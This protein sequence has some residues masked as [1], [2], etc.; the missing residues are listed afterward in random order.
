MPHIDISKL[1]PGSPEIAL[2]ARWRVDAFAVLGGDIETERATLDACAADTARHATLIA[3]CDG[4]PAGTCLLVPS[5]I[6][7]LHDVSPWLV[8]LYVAPAFRKRGVGQA[9]VRAIESEAAT[10]GHRRLYLYT[11]EAE[12]FYARLGWRVADRVD[13][14]GFATALMVRELQESQAA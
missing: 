8:G 5:E 4:V 6:D 11:D 1:S 2:V 9:L 3:R 7:P 14:Q 13:W 10:R 12:D